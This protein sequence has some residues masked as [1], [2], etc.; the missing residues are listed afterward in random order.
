M[1]NKISGKV[2]SRLTLYHSILCEY[3]EEGI[4][5]ISSPQIAA[6]L[7]IDDSQVRK[8]FGLLKNVGRCRVGYNVKELKDKIEKTLGFAHQKDAFIIGAGHL[9]L[10]LAKYDNFSSYGLNIIA[11]FDNDPYKVDM[12]INN[13]QIFHITKLPNLVHRLNVDIAI[14]TVPKNQAQK[15]A[16]FLVASD[17][18]Y[19]W[20]FTPA[21]LRVPD[22]IKVWN[23]NLIASFLQFACKDI[24]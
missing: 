4:D 1:D 18:K 13:K 24:E 10:A 23:E 14:L 11:L 7:G 6:R 19:I 17:I 2:T 15:V 3:I 20:N 5:L 8:D 22:N 12:H 21:V 9:G 16:D